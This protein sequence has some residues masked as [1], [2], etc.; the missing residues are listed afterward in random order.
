MA[1][2]DQQ[3]AEA[4]GQRGVEGLAAV[5]LLVIQHLG[6]DAG[7]LRAHQAVGI[8]AVGDHRGDAGRIVALGDAVDQR[9]QVAA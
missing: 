2:L 1:G 8:G 9:L 6:G 4:F 5:E 3:V 7:V